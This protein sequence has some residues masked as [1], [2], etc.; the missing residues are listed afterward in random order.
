MKNHLRFVIKFK[1]I[2]ESFIKMLYNK[3]KGG[4]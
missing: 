2:I 1:F 3:Y 4:E